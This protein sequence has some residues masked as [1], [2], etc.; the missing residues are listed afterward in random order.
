MCLR[1]LPFALPRGISGVESR[2]S[3][4]SGVVVGNRNDLVSK[5]NMNVGQNRTFFRWENDSYL[6]LL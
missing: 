1:F 2:L 4:Y 6:D 3:P 5:Y